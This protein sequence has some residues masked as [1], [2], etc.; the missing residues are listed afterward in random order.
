[1]SMDHAK[2]VLAGIVPNR[3]DLLLYAMQHLD[4]DHFRGEVQ[5]GIWRAIERYYDVAGDVLP[6]KTLTDLLSSSKTLETSK[7]L[8]YEEEFAEIESLTLADHEF[9]YAVDALKDQRAEQLTGE[10]ITTAFEILMRG[11]EVGRDVLE[12]HKEARTYA[13]SQFAHIDKLD[14]IEVAPEGDMRYEGSDILKEYIDRKAGKTGQGILTG[15]PSVDKASGG[16]QKGEL[17]LVCAYT[18]QGKTQLC[19]QTAWDAAIQQGKNVFFATSETVRTT[20]RR[21]IIARHSRLPQ[22]GLAK[23]LDSTDI[24]NGTLSPAEEKSLKEVVDDLDN[25]PNYGKLYIAQIPRG[26]TLSYLEARMNRQGALW[27]IDLGIMDYLALLKSDRKRNSER[28]EFNEILK[29]AKVYATSFNE[30]SGLPLISPWQIKQEA[31]KNAQVTGAYGLASLSDTS[32]AEKS[33]DQIIT[34]LRQPEQPNQLSLQFLKMRDG[35]VPNAISLE[36]DFRCAYLGDKKS[37]GYSLSGSSSG[38]STSLSSYGL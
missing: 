15:I 14:N 9:R 30:G 22:F 2:N 6:K 10:A 36:T 17:T 28:E 20:V 3:K 16:F 8:L 32:E 1:M 34:L 19:C 27:N 4:D 13:Y 35:E 7:A 31:Y 18:N 11:A 26:A 33:S 24:K 37:G 29:D 12:G 23:G 25:N 21:R 5:K 38:S